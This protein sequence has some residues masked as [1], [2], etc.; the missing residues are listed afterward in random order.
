MPGVNGA[1]CAVLCCA[2][3]GEGTVMQ[4]TEWEG[5]ERSVITEKKTR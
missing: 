3:E 4:M 1:I 2:R 5:S